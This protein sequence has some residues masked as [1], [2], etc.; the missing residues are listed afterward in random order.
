[1]YYFPSGSKWLTPPS[2]KCRSCMCI[3]GQR[4]CI[5]CDR[6]LKIDV[7]NN[8]NNNNN[9]QQSPAIGEFRL[10]PTVLTVMKMTPCL[11]QTSISSHRLIF[12][13]QQ[14]WFE[15]RCYFCSQRGGRLITC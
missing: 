10:L 9:S 8:N 3:N 15:Q 2:D 7:S 6:I 4:K 1:M 14:T 11:L 5:N 12:P 13:G